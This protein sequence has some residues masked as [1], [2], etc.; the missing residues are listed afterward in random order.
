MKAW[1]NPRFTPA[2]SGAALKLGRMMSG[3][4]KNAA[5]EVGCRLDLTLTG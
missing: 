2:I 4:L 3:T 1:Q 5:I